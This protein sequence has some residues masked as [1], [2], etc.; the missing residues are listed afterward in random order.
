MQ[1]L[2]HE[3]FERLQENFREITHRIDQMD[4]KLTDLQEVMDQHL[5]GTAATGCSESG[6]VR[7]RKRKTPVTL[8]V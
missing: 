5:S 8:Q 2:V 6:C 4:V 3:N 1:S 7:K